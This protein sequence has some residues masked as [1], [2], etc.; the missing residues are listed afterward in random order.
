MRAGVLVITVTVRDGRGGT[1][2][3]TF[4]LTVTDP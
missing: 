3:Q 1:D 4:T 2:S